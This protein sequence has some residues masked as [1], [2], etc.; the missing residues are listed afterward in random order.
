MAFDP[1]WPGTGVGPNGTPATG[2]DLPATAV[3]VATA[4]EATGCPF[5][6]PSRTPSLA[7][8]TAT[9]I[10]SKPISGTSHQPRRGIRRRADSTAARRFRNRPDF[11]ACVRR[12]RGGVYGLGTGGGLKILAEGVPVSSV[13]H[14]PRGPVVPMSRIVGWTGHRPDIFRDPDAARDVVQSTAQNLVSEERFEHFLVGGQRGVDTWA[15]QTAIALGVSFTLILPVEPALFTSDWSAADHA[16]LV[17]VLARASDVRVVGQGD[18]LAAA[19]TERN[20]QLAT[21]ADLLVAV[22]TQLACGGTAE[23]IA[24]ARA[25]GTSVRELVLPIAQ[26]AHSVRGRGI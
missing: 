9:R 24:L 3:L 26:I 6:P 10:G 2:A 5:G 23:T 15:A 14:P 22:W 8:T 19:Y 1:A 12:A 25:S 16:T 7:R 20:R 17:S 18:D 13:A 4:A 11:T 21:Q